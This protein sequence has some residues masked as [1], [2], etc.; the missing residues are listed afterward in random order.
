MSDPLLLD[1]CG[2]LWLAAGH[3]RLSAPARRRIDSATLVGVSAITAWEVGLKAARGELKLPMEAEEWF[4]G[5][6]AHHRL[7][8]FEITPR[9]AF[10]ANRLPWHHRDPADRF[11]LATARLHHMAVVTADDNFATYGVETFV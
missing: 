10:E 1:T 5:A 6:I 2:L 7:Q 9:I 8:V 3:R 4:E 11:I